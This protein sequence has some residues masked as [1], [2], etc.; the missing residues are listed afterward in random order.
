MNVTALII[1]IELDNLGA[2]GQATKVEQLGVDFSF[3]EDENDEALKKDFL[4]C[5]KTI[6]ARGKK[7]CCL[8]LDMIIVD[9]FGIT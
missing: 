9:L 4:Q 8:R 7:G 1:L 6:K 3:S 5:A 2:G